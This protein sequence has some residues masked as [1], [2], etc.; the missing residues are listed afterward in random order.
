MPKLSVL[1]PTFERVAWLKECLDSLVASSQDCEIVVSD[2]ASSD[3][4]P[5]LVR[6]YADPRVVYVRQPENIGGLAN[7]EHLLA[8]ARGEYLCLFGDD[9]RLLPGGLDRKVTLLDRRPDVDLVYSPWHRID[10]A[11]KTLGTVR[12]PGLLPHAYAGGR[13]EFL[14][15]LAT[16]Y[17]MLQAVVF[18]RALY[19]EEGGFE[20]RVGPGRSTDLVCSHDWQM[21]LRYVRGRRTAFLAEPTVAIRYHE[22]NATSQNVRDG[23]FVRDK[24]AVWRGWLLEADPPPVVDALRFSWMEQALV[25]DATHAFDGDRA[26]VEPLVRELAQLKEAYS[27]R[28]TRVV[29]ACLH[30]PTPASPAAAPDPAPR[31]GELALTWVSPVFDPSGYADEARHFIRSL[32]GAGVTVAARAIGRHSPVFR[33][34][35]DPTARAELDRALAREPRPTDVTVLHCP[36]Y[37]FRRVTGAAYVVGRTMYE[38]DSLPPDW[39]ARC[40]ELDELW[41]PSEHNLASFRAAG[42]TARL[43]KIGEGVDAERFRPGLEPLPIPGAR[44]T[45]FLS[46]FEWIFRKGFDVLLR[47]WAR[48]FTRDDDVTLVLRTYP[49]NAIE[50]RDNKAEIEARIDAF[51]E[52]ELG[53]PRASAAPIVV[54]GDQIPDRDMP[55]L[56]AAAHAYVAPSRGEGWGR[57]H[58]E[59]MAAGLPVLATRWS[60]NLEFMNDQNS[61]LI[62]LEGLVPV[63]ERAET[64]QPGH[65]WAEPSATHLATLLRRVVVEPDAMAALGARARDDVARLHRWDSVAAAVVSRLR[66]IGAERDARAKAAAAAERDAA[67]KTRVVWQGSQFVH[68]SLG[69]VNRE[70]CRGLLDTGEVELSVVPF[71][72]HQFEPSET[73]PFRGVARRVKRPLSAPAE[74]H[75][76]HQWPPL[77]E[78]PASGAWV[79]IQPWEHGGIPAPW[80]APMRDAVDEVW[81]PSTWLKSCY[82]ESGVPSDKVVVVP[83]GVDTD[84]FRPDGPKLPLATKKAVKLLFVGGVIRRKGIDVLIET[85]LSTF[86]ADDDVCLVIK[87]FGAESVYKDGSAHAA[88]VELAARTRGDRRLPEI[89]YHHDTM[90]DEQMA[91]LYRSADALVMPYRGEGFG[92]PIAEAMASGL[93]V[94]VTGYGACLDFCTAETAYLVPAT[95]VPLHDAALPP[96][97]IGYFWAEADRAALAAAM[98]RVVRTPDEA[99]EVG[100]RARERI[101]RDFS[102]GA[103]AKTALARIEA[104]ARRAPVRE[105]PPPVFRPDAAP[106]PLDG[107]KRTAFFH[108]PTF[109][110]SAWK[111]VVGAFGSAF[112]GRD[113][114]T[115]VLWLDP[116]QGVLPEAVGDE[117]TR[118]WK[119]RAGRPGGAPDLLLVPDDLNLTG[120]ARLYAAIDC[121]L[122][123]GDRVQAARARASGKDAIADATPKALRAYAES[124]AKR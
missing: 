46:I 47:A 23:H 67:G 2:N 34:S 68:H 108:H 52:R 70:V 21:L 59:A 49:I 84:L 39:V 81:V 123:A 121:V 40:N 44:G 65:L 42:V 29:D 105:A 87:G 93:P 115:L 80:I 6:S 22:S 43:V 120:I 19:D 32:S 3:G 31:A 64:V 106:W 1:V 94:V 50:G 60:G 86:T 122:P 26:R 124:A 96:S 58:I 17:I 100:R 92:L 103:A 28:M 48:A 110:S 98:R 116:R 73:S 69:R 36:A 5:D 107:R 4:T 104:L 75:V 78:P 95:V 89:E 76:R 113:D 117:I 90:S 99:R 88:I 83:N 38:T 118:I 55:R 66:G 7:F 14:D 15:L 33:D 56:Y 53:A 111:D 62:D 97:P 101:Q 12:W 13:D 85:Y 109:A 114:V 37:A 57:P 24:L 79:M 63:D 35:L 9:D 51:F 41:V 10:T 61:L 112:T 74:V 82:V 119:A 16:S 77:F 27:A 20:R 54:L 71:E 11:G 30:A 8:I 72:P 102:W 91:A 18:R 45:V 25:G